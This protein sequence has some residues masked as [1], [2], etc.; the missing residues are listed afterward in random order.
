LGILAAIEPVTAFLAGLDPVKVEEFGQAMGRVLI[1]VS[2]LVV[3]LKGIGLATAGVAALAGAGY[4]AAAAFSAFGVAVAAVFAKLALV[5]AIGAAVNSVVK[6][7]FDVDMLKGFTDWVSKAFKSVKEFVG[8]KSP[9][10]LDQA[11]VDRENK[12]LAQRGKVIKETGTV[13]RQVIDPFKTLREQI[14]GLAEDYARVNK[15]NIDNINL[16][17]SLIGLGRTESETRK[18]LADLAKREADEI[19]KLTDQKAKLTKEQQQAGLGGEIDKQIVKIKEQTKADMTATESAI[20]NSELRTMA[21]QLELFSILQELGGLELLD[22]KIYSIKDIMSTEVWKTLMHT[23]WDEK[24]SS[25]CKILCGN[26]G[27]FIKIKEQ[28]NR[29]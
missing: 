6:F 26:S 15:A 10:F 14:S 3:Y 23:K 16:T 1:V 8:I 21:R 27:P 29:A 17:T 7:A 2:G 22:S 18:A 5:I 28:I 12:L 20:R 25:A 13:V 19:R 24:T 4:T 9:T 11:E